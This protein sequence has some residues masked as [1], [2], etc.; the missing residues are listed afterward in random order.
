MSSK[1]QRGQEAARLLEDETLKAAFEEIEKYYVQQWRNSL[2]DDTGWG[3]REDAH[4]VLRAMDIF[5]AQLTSFIV[6]GRIA[7]TKLNRRED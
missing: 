1:K 4:N 6:D 3:V 2:A 7:E 5:K